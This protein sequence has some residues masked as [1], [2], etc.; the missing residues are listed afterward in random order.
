MVMFN[1]VPNL[2]TLEALLILRIE[3]WGGEHSR[4]SRKLLLSPRDCWRGHSSEIYIRAGT[5][6]RY[7]AFLSWPWAVLDTPNRAGER[8]FVQGLIH[9]NLYQFSLPVLVPVV[10][11][12]SPPSDIT[13][14]SEKD[15]KRLSSI[16]DMVS[17]MLKGRSASETTCVSPYPRLVLTFR[18]SQH[19]E[20]RPMSMKNEA[21]R[22]FPK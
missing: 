1:E 9:G 22:G 2:R 17:I 21:S 3:L 4:W 16:S 15:W 11:E 19:F 14:W 8:I 7:F 6:V 12:K 5:V 20:Q 18:Y 10:Q 13:F